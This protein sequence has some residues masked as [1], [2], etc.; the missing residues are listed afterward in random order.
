MLV[1]DS[2]DPTELE[3]LTESTL[4]GRVLGRGSSGGILALVDEAVTAGGSDDLY[5][6]WGSISG[7]VLGG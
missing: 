1:E 5:R 3:P 7:A 6:Q 2:P 4:W